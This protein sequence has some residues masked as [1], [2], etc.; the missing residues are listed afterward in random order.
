MYRIGRSILKYIL[1]FVFFVLVPV[2]RVT[3]VWGF[4]LL[5]NIISQMWSGL[6]L[7]LYYIPDPSLVISYREEYMNEVWWFWYVHKIHVIGV[8]SIFILSYLHIIK[9]IFIKNF[10]GAELEGWVSGSYAFLV[11]HVV[12][13]LGITLSTNH[14][15]DL[16]LTIGATIFWSLFMYKHK[17][18]TLLF[19]N[20]H[21]NMEQLLRFMVAH[22][23][24]AWYYVYLVQT[25]VMYIHELWESDS[26]KGAT[27]DGSTPKA[28]W[29]VDALTKESSLTMFIYVLSMVINILW[30]YPDMKILNFSFFEQWSETE[31]EDMN[32]FIVGPH[33]Y[34]R[35]H[36][37]LLT[38]CAKHYEGLFWLVMY[39]AIL[40]YMPM[41]SFFF[42]PSN[43]TLIE[44]KNENRPMIESYIQLFFFISF[45]ASMLYVGGTLPCARFYYEEDEG[46]FGNIWLR[47]SYQYLYLY[48]FF[49]IHFI[50]WLEFY[51]GLNVKNNST[52]NKKNALKWLEILY[53]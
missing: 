14:L 6:L 3:S 34:F 35:P 36:M 49:I 46:F 40:A 48:M 29:F 47:L 11:F 30:N 8:D 13:F 18:Q 50:D 27:Q 22:Y 51:F 21:L 9:K 41:L 17:F 2:F 25:H 38:I 45:I 26:N 53:L 31:F 28:S 16:T 4:T 37:G 20:R 12:V 23:I 15:G 39:Y 43:K 24:L 44:F 52:N 5:I 1:R 19:T 7:S 10:I 32:F 33:W 42:K